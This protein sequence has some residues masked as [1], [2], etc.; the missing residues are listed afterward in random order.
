ME[1]KPSGILA[2]CVAEL[3]SQHAGE[4]EHHCPSA[5]VYFRELCP[6]L[7]IQDK[8]FLDAAALTLKSSISI[9]GASV[10]ATSQPLVTS[11]Y[12]ERRL[13]RSMDEKGFAVLPPGV[14]QFNAN[15]PTTA[16]LLDAA[17]KGPSLPKS[18]GVSGSSTT[19]ITLAALASAAAILEAAG[20]PATFLLAFDEVWVALAQLEPVLQKSSGGCL[21]N[22]DLLCWHVKPGMAGFSPHRDRQPMD[23]P[24]SFRPDGSPKY[25]TCWVALGGANTA[26]NSI[27]YV[28][29]RGIDP[30]YA[31][32]DDS[33][34]DGG[35]GGSGGSGDGGK[36]SGEGGDPLATCLRSDKANYQHIRAL[37]TEAGG[38]CLFSH[39]TI[40]WGSSSEPLDERREEKDEETPP[41]PPTMRAVTTPRVS[42]S[43][44]SSDPEFE[45][46]YMDRHHPHLKAASA[47]ASAAM[48][49][50]PLS[51]RL[52]LACAQM[53]V[54]HQ[55]FDTPL[56]LLRNMYVNQSYYAGF[57]CARKMCAN[58]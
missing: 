14:L 5:D 15:H 45:P 56:P 22:F 8:A 39:R 41:P 37:P 49:V 12:D 38:A 35:G 9:N 26:Q 31:L 47:S 25:A 55:R 3:S 46:P 43:F 48:M 32:G 24:S 10:A 27:L 50:P 23:V 28:I 20:W 16:D 33:S 44:A 52:A 19:V 2:S 34:G 54:Y 58:N 30:G 11:H 21:C 53:I 6:A 36:G 42:F 18:G 13:R 57:F 1:P 51:L 40:H 17:S 29:P 7:H 4:H